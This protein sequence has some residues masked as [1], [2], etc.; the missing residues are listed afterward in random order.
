[1]PGGRLRK[2]GGWEGGRRWGEGS[3][4]R[5][6]GGRWGER[7]E[8]GAVG[9]EGGKDGGL[10]GEEAHRRQITKNKTKCVYKHTQ[11]DIC[12]YDTYMYAHIYV[13]IRTYVYIHTY[14]YICIHVYTCKE[15]NVN[16]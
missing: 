6:G 16:R 9:G 2:C 5:G 13:C 11:L 14:V 12:L 8:R 4:D 15:V 3:G 1:V 10:E 7:G